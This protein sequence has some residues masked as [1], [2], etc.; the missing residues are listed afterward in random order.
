MGKS[1]KNS[2]NAKVAKTA[3]NS[4]KAALEKLEQHMDKLAKDVNAMNKDV[5]Y[6]GS[7]ATSWYQLVNVVYQNMVQ[8]DKGVTEFQNELHAVFAKAGD[9][10]GI[11]F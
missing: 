7:R 4:T 11:Q 8:F 9:I 6:G 3:Y 10:S 1:N 2:V 5:W